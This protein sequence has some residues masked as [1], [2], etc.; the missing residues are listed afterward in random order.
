MDSESSKPTNVG[1]NDQLGLEPERAG[2]D[3][4][5]CAMGY[6]YTESTD[7][8]GPDDWSTDDVVKAFMAGYELAQRH[9]KAAAGKHVRIPTGAD[10]AKA[11]ATVAIAWLR[12]HAPQEL[13][14]EFRA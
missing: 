7:P 2:F 13:R 12:E 1:S 14:P 4:H 11:M 3:L 6:A 5:D 8:A 10:E 9:E